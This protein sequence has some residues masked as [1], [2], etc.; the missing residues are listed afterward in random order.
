MRHGRT[1]GFTVTGG[2]V[3]ILCVVGLG[4]AAL[5]PELDAAEREA[6]DP[7]KTKVVFTGRKYE[8]NHLFEIRFYP[9]G[10]LFIL[11]SLQSGAR[12]RNLTN[13]KA[14]DVQDPEVSYDA[15]KALFSMRRDVRDSFHL[16]EINVDG[17]GLKQLT[18]G[19]QDDMNAAYLPDGRI[20][21]C[22]TRP[23]FM[24][25]YHREPAALLHVMNS[26]GSGVEQI[27][28]NLS[29]DVTPT[30]L[31]DGR[32]LYPRWEHHGPVNK[33][34]L[35]AVDPDGTG[36]FQYY[37]ARERASF[38]EPQ[39]MDDGR[40]VAVLS[41]AA[42][43][44]LAG[45]LAIIDGLGVSASHTVITP[46]V[47]MERIYPERSAKGNK[48]RSPCPLPDGRLLVSYAE[49]GNWD[50]GIYTLGLDG[51]DRRLIYNDPNLMEFNPKPVLRRERQRIIPS[52]TDRSKTTGTLFGTNVYLNSLTQIP[53]G[54]IKALRVLEGLP[55]PAG[56]DTKVSINRMHEVKR[57]LGEVPVYPDGS[58]YLEAPANTPL[59]FQTIGQDG[60]MLT[61]QRTW[62]W[63]KPGENRG[64]IGCHAVRESRPAKTTNIMAM[65]HPPTKVGLDRDTIQ[66]PITFVKD[67]QPILSRKCVKCHSYSDTDLDRLPAG[68]L[69][70]APDH[71]YAY[72][73]AYANVRYSVVAD[74]SPRTSYLVWK[75]LGKQLSRYARARARRPRNTE[76][77]G[78]VMP[79][80]NSGLA[81][82]AAE[83]QTIIKWIE[84]GAV[85]RDYETQGY[86]AGSSSKASPAAMVLA[87]RCGSAGC[88][89]GRKASSLDVNL[90]SYGS[91]IMRETVNYSR[92]ENSLLLRAALAQRA[93]GLPHAGGDVFRD[94]GDVD[95]QTLLAYVREAAKNKRRISIGDNGGY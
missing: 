80:P 78:A 83:K 33:F 3:V 9:G 82:T 14:G 94:T 11:D 50:F 84:L 70:L 88:H 43:R 72:N 22:S 64:C 61:N 15:D 69:D 5:F 31:S 26:D 86:L 23:G 63:V 66:P 44:F 47:K 85:Y 91:P 38:F 8:S 35:F 34:P 4:G 7:A 76:L 81:L 41:P 57:I 74:S 68:G 30:M 29:H 67:V 45:P 95:Y 6:F 60:I 16:W 92:P 17:S 19:P 54:E 24:D 49:K 42:N 1:S 90:N 59:H 28:F 51:G 65:R 32:I 75:I 18:F 2:T 52:S 25:E 39:E 77:K 48:Y 53:P 58:F 46:G 87:R 10:N 13:L 55:R 62:L 37:G 27:S 73:V 21:F 56:G 93:S 12:A 36:L 71:S 20:A 40:L 89:D 79:P